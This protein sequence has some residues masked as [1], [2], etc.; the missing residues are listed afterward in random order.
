VTQIDLTKY[1]GQRVVVT[2]GAGF[3]GGH[4]VDALLGAG[5]ERVA[6]VDNFFLGKLENLTQAQEHGNR[7]V[8]YREDAAERT[9]MEAVIAAEKPDIVFNLAT[10]ALMY[11]FFNPAGACKVNLDI[12]L[13]LCDLLRNGAYGRLLHV[14][15]SEVY[16][17]AV[18]VPME[19][20]HPLLAETTYAAGKA[21]ADLA[22]ASY[23]NQ[24]S[25]DVRTVRPFNNYGPRQ[26]DGAMAAIVPITIKRIMDGEKP[27]L[28]GDGLQTRDFVYVD[29]TVDG[30]MRFGLSDI[31]RGGVFNLASGRETSMKDIV[32]GICVHLGYEGEIDWR[33]ER[34]ADVRRHMAGVAKAVATIGPLAPTR[35]EDGLKRTI[36]W[37]RGKND[38]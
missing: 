11:S 37:Y 1:T 10:K 34:T 2:G 12:A 4:L 8:L 9:A 32:E 35:L 38:T 25:I 7:F 29:D 6:V 15:T 36:D 20:N 23:V 28:T 5:C 13:V 19:E 24:Y 17:S 16:G 21:A 26:N 27:I 30:L 14:S 22:I 31:A 3:I 18:H 33:P